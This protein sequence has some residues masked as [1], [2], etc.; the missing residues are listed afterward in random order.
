MN[1]NEM[2]DEASRLLN[3]Q[4]AAKILTEAYWSRERHHHLYCDGSV[5]VMEG[6]LVEAGYISLQEKTGTIRVYS[7]TEK[8]ADFGRRLKIERFQFA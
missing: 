5:S 3:V 6:F 4:N 8:G 7:L 2:N 1:L